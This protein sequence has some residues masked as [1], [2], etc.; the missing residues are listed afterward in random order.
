METRYMESAMTKTLQNEIWRKCEDILTKHEST[1]TIMLYR[2]YIIV[3]VISCS[4]RVFFA[5]SPFRFF[6]H[7]IGTHTCAVTPQFGVKR[8]FQFNSWF[9]VKYIFI[10][11]KKDHYAYVILQSRL[12]HHFW[13]CFVFKIETNLCA[14]FKVIIQPLETHRLN[15]TYVGR[16]VSLHLKLY[17]KLYRL[18]S[19]AGT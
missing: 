15:R 1:K 3:S 6:H 11:M 8:T 12:K 16:L 4:F 10:Y 13:C 7:R 17:R 2:I 19:Y 9:I 18:Y 14:G 5:V